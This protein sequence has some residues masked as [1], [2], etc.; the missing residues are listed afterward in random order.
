MWEECDFQDGRD[1]FDDEG[2]SKH[3]TPARKGRLN[4]RP[5]SKTLDSKGRQITRSR[6]ANTSRLHNISSQAPIETEN[7]NRNVK[8]AMDRQKSIIESQRFKLREQQKQ[9]D[10]LRTLKEQLDKGRAITNKVIIAQIQVSLYT[11]FEV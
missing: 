10:E 1:I 9:I 11:Y 6:S 4:S 7:K 2:I 8:S 5:G 3:S